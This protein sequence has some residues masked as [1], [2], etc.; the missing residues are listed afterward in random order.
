MRILIVDDEADIRRILRILL[1]KAKY[2]VIEAQDGLSAIEC[3]RNDR[4]IDL[5]IM[6]VMMPN[7]TGIEATAA[8]HSQRKSQPSALLCQTLIPATPQFMRGET[9]APRAKNNTLSSNKLA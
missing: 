8:M 3:V 9:F 1:E 6:D 2:E 4:S 7:M 5:C